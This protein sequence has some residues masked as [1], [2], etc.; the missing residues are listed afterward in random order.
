VNS[1]SVEI[2]ISCD[3]MA[4]KVVTT[5]ARIFKTLLFIIG[6]IIGIIILFI[7]IIPLFGPL[8]LKKDLN[9]EQELI[10]GI[11]LMIPFYTGFITMSF[12]MPTYKLIKPQVKI[13]RSK[14]IGI[15]RDYKE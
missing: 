10:D 6:N 13:E 4:I 1:N 5:I 8:Q 9:L 14:I 7:I 2:R 12:A 15:I 3:I 11:K